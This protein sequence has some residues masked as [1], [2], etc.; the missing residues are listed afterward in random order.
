MWSAAASQ[1][2]SGAIQQGQQQKALNMSVLV[3]RDYHVVLPRVR[4]VYLRIW[5]AW[6]SMLQSCRG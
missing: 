1:L 3:P 5:R 4:V 2:L 6:L